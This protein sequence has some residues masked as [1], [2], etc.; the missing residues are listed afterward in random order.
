MGS[1]L[2]IGL[3]IVAGGIVLLVLG[4]DA[5]ESFASD[6]SELIDNTP[7][8]KAIWLMTLGGVLALLGAGTLLTT[9]RG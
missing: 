2:L 4:L 6:V 8:D 5:R 1:R 7:S 3:G 9:S